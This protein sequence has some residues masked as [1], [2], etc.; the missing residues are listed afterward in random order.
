MDVDNYWAVYDNETDTII[1]VHP[2]EGL[3]K[4]Y[5]K[6]CEKA[7]DVFVELEA[8]TMRARYQV[9]NLSDCISWM[10]DGQVKT[11]MTV[12]QQNGWAQTD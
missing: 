7:N 10:V 2:F 12:F 3:A 6:E 11:S 1:S 9:G 8:K 4:K 5:H